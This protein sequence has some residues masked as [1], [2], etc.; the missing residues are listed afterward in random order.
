MP[1]VM[2]N[3]AASSSLRAA[4]QPDSLLRPSRAE[5]IGHHD[6]FGGRAPAGV[7]APQVQGLR[8][9]FSS[10]S[11]ACNGTW[12]GGASVSMAEPGS[13][14]FLG[15]WKGTGSGCGPRGHPDQ[16][17]VLSLGSPLLIPPVAPQLRPCRGLNVEM[18]AGFAA[19]SRGALTGGSGVAQDLRG[20]RTVAV[21]PRGHK[22][23]SPDRAVAP[24]GLR[25]NE[26]PAFFLYLVFC[27]SC[28]S[29]GDQ[30]IIRFFIF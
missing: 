16:Q 17:L 20:C 1:T 8:L 5:S 29:E 23:P 9:P 14:R 3:S 28:A 13:A 26:T 24:W 10:P 4:R 15:R 18:E 12:T 30:V 21:D 27:K 11:G 25:L 22:E 19:H 6:D 2:L 7:L